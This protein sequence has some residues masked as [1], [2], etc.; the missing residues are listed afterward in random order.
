MKPKQFSTGD[1]LP[2]MQETLNNGGSFRLMV[3]GNSMLPFL[4]HKR[5]V[6]VV[7]PLSAPPKKGDILLYLRA[8]DKVI[9]HRVHKIHPSG[10]LL[11]CGD[12]QFAPEPIH[13]N[14]VLARVSHIQRND[15]L[16]S[17]SSLSWRAVCAV[18]RWLHPVRPHLLA[19]L[20]KLKLIQYAVPE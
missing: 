2:L 13:P 6:V 8:S 15:T 1:A 17:C 4:R 16:I 7:A 14:Q 18:W 3:T 5:D 11:M 20:K 12:S 19:I 9:L 10:A